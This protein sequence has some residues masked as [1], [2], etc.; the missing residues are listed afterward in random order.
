LAEMYFV[1]ENVR[2]KNARRNK[3]VSRRPKVWTIRYDTINDMTGFR[4]MERVE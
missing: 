1:I 2:E 3:T 4:S